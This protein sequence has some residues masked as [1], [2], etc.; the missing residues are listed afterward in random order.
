M[1]IVETKIF[2]RQ[3][4]ELIND[5]EYR[6]FQIYLANDPAKGKIIKG[7]NS[8]RKIRWRTSNKGKSAGIRVIYFWANLKET[9]LLLY[10]F[11]K[12]EQIDLTQ[13]QIKILNKIIEKEYKK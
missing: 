12:S 5:D 11:S 7:T 2:T 9:I 1:I 8:L 13:K 6:E 4:T 3:I 10:A